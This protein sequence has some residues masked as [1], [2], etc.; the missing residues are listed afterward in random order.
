MDTLEE[1]EVLSMISNKIKYDGINSSLVPL[2]EYIICKD[3]SSKDKYLILKF[4]NSYKRELSYIKCQIRELNDSGDLLRVDSFE[5]KD[6]NQK[7][8]TQFVPFQKLHILDECTKI[9][10]SLLQAHFKGYE[11]KVNDQGI[12][13]NDVDEVID[14]KKNAKQK[15]RNIKSRKSMLI[16]IIVFSLIVLALTSAVSYYLIDKHMKNTYYLSNE[17]FEFSVTDN[18]ATIMD[19]LTTDSNVVIPEKVEGFTVCDIDRD[20]FISLNLESI[21]INAR[22]ITI[23][24]NQFKNMNKLKS[25]T[26]SE[27]LV[28]EDRAFEGCTSLKTVNIESVQKIN[29]YAFNGCSLLE[30]FSNDGVLEIMVGAFSDCTSLTTVSVP[31]AVLGENCLNNTRVISLDYLSSSTVYFGG[32]FGKANEI[33]KLENIKYNGQNIPFM[34]FRNLDCT[35][36]SFNDDCYIGYGAFIGSTLAGYRQNDQYEQINGTL[37]SVKQGI[38]NL[39]IL[40]DIKEIRKGALRNSELSSIEISTKNLVLNDSLNYL[41]SLDELVINDSVQSIEGQINIPIN[42]LTV[43]A[44]SAIL[45]DLISASSV[46]EIR[47]EGVSIPDSFLAGITGVKRVVIASD[48]MQLGNKIFGDKSD[49]IELTLPNIINNVDELGSFTALKKLTVTESSKDELKSYFIQNIPTL[50]S[51]DLPTNITEIGLPLIGKNMNSLSSLRVSFVG[52]SSSINA[53][54]DEFNLSAQALKNLTIDSSFTANKSL[55]AASL[56]TLKLN[57]N[58]NGVANGYLAGSNS[59]MYL[60][61]NSDDLSLPLAQLFNNNTPVS[62]SYVSISSSGI[63][64]DGYLANTSVKAL[65]LVDVDGTLASFEESSSLEYVYFGNNVGANVKQS[66]YNQNDYQITVIYE[67]RK[68][69]QYSFNAYENI[70]PNHQT[71][72][73]YNGNEYLLDSMFVYDY[74]QVLSLL[75]IDSNKVVSFS[76]NGSSVDLQNNVY[77]TNNKIDVKVDTKINLKLASAA[78]IVISTSYYDGTILKTP[79]KPNESFVISKPD[80]VGNAY[81]AGWYFD[82]KRH[83][84]VPSSFV[85]TN[86]ITLYSYYVEIANP[87]SLNMATAF[88]VPETGKIDLQLVALADSSMSIII[89]GKGSATSCQMSSREVNEGYTMLCFNVSQYDLITITYT[90]KASE[91]ITAI[92]QTLSSSTPYLET[93]TN[94]K[95]YS[96]TNVGYVIG[97]DIT[98]PTLEGFSFKGYFDNPNGEGVCYFDEN[99]KMINVPENDCILYPFY[100]FN[101]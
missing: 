66:L 23:Y 62:L 6:F 29:S 12:N 86:S 92:H 31:N 84:R 88:T 75:G 30:E 47:I 70:S 94:G 46:S 85:A 100:I 2:E 26:A 37:I 82:S 17:D 4:K 97:K 10:Y 41:P 28:I 79:L 32:I 64:A 59:L 25:F 8:G 74:N 36:I 69:S 87:I 89:V 24:Q 13:T 68:D 5:Y 7:S 42:K 61:I 18:K 38:S 11:F 3:E 50:E 96:F 27:L 76:D 91:V 77:F 44:R 57:G 67:G 93:I 78:D 16:P 71:S 65:K 80:N 19:I 72:F 55:N 49:I 83:N 9:E 48:A 33:L 1:R 73:S 56:Q 39:C 95:D 101:N 60:E 58:I 45:S 53:S 43:R 40:D 90:G 99:G 81:F 15:I 52:Q 21:T 51:L 98:A 35:D 34:Y 54:L 22:G 14:S 63:L 20:A